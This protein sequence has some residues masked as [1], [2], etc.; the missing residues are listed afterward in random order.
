MKL[1][2]ID[3]H[4]AEE[5]TLD[6]E[7]DVLQGLLARRKRLPPKYF[8]DHR[9]SEL[10]ERIC[11]LPEYYPTRTELAI[12][13]E[14]AGDMGRAIG[15][16]ATLIELGSGASVK[17]RLLL[18]QLPEPEAYLPVD[19][20]REFL[21][22][23]SEKLA[24]DYF[25]LAVVPVCADYST[26]VYSLRVA[27]ADR[28]NKVVFFPGSTIGNLERAQATEFLAG[29]AGL[30]GSG[31]RMLV[32]F[33]LVKEVRILEAAYND[34]QGV[35]ALFNLNLLERIN[36]E[37]GADFDLSAFQHHAYFNLS[38][39]RIEMHLISRREQVV[40]IAG[41]S[42]SFGHEETI[43]TESSHK[44]TLESFDAMARP[45]GFRRVREWLDPDRHF[46][47]ALLETSESGQVV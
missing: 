4:G 36:R 1:N 44:Y 6:F 20:S 27:L 35:T 30:L 5:T 38:E 18:D 21:R 12:L 14:H 9:G 37:L 26:F 7:R 15:R 2:V 11:G 19:I 43:H 39:Q 41:Q 45:A 17:T 42:I 33:D 23:S 28:A 34:A 40:R 8:Y 22:E 32:G 25:N 46:C 31:G 13:R 16:R 10:F 24:E 3:L 29:C 47:V